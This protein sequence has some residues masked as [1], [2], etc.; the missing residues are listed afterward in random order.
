MKTAVSPFYSLTNCTVTFD[1]PTVTDNSSLSIRACA[2]MQQHFG[3]LN[4]KK[5]YQQINLQYTVEFDSW[6]F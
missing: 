5:A 2:Q 6:R 3:I 4:Y 1:F